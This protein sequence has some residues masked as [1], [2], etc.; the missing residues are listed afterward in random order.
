[1]KGKLKKHTSY[2][3]KSLVPISLS[4]PTTDE[5]RRS[6]KIIFRLLQIMARF[7]KDVL[8]SLISQWRISF[9]PKHKST[10]NSDF[11]FFFL[12]KLFSRFLWKLRNNLYIS[13]YPFPLMFAYSVHM[14]RF[15]DWRNDKLLGIIHLINSNLYYVILNFLGGGSWIAGVF[16]FAKNG[17]ILAVVD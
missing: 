16:S 2:D 9:S 7:P 5:V 8:K 3:P 6:L 15:R 14:R 12:C 4:F 1:M 17:C 11:F 10:T 13:S